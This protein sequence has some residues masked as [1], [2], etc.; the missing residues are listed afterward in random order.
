MRVMWMLLH[1]GRRC[2]SSPLA[3]SFAVICIKHTHSGSFF[4]AATTTSTRAVPRRRHGGVSGFFTH[5]FMV[6]LLFLFG[7]C[8]VRV[9]RIPNGMP[10]FFFRLL[11]RQLVP[12]PRFMILFEKAASSMLH[13][14]QDAV[15]HERFLEAAF[16]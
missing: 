15:H 11:A 8:F 12:A 9:Y 4:V 6:F 7:A 1:R 14:V 3:R 13:N 2:G 10:H 5:P 16:P